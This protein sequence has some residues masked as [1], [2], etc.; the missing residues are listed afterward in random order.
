M[1]ISTGMRVL[2]GSIPRCTKQHG[3]GWQRIAPSA[4]RYRVAG[5]ALKPLSPGLHHDLVLPNPPTPDTASSRGWKQWVA[6]QESGFLHQASLE[7]E[8]GRLR[9]RPGFTGSSPECWRVVAGFHSST[10]AAPHI[11]NM[12]GQLCPNVPTFSAAGMTTCLPALRRPSSGVAW[13]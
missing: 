3:C 12:P 9:A 4:S 6:G 1:T 5:V 8:P 10:S 2:S 11:V 13:Y 7:Q